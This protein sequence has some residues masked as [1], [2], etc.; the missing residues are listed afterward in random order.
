M[1][2]EAGTK[3][4]PRTTASLPLPMLERSVSDRLIITPNFDTAREVDALA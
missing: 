4:T 3:S 1:S 2:C